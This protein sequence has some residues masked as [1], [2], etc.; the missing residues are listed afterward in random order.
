MWAMASLT[1][2]T[3]SH[4]HG[5]GMRKKTEWTKGRKSYGKTELA[6]FVKFK[7]CCYHVTFHLD[8]ELEHTL[9]AG[10]SGDHCVQVWRWSDIC[11]REEAICAKS[12]QT[13][14]RTPL[15]C[16]SSLEWANNNSY[17]Q[18][19]CALRQHYCLTCLCLFCG[20]ESFRS[21][22]TWNEKRRQNCVKLW[23]AWRDAIHKKMP[24]PRAPGAKH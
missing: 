18:N 4:R 6:I 24:T 19:G 11:L 12:L 22:R 17:C 20:H 21:R 1:V 23:H 5:I 14:R 16:I 7:M 9:D 3:H 2:Q 10:S 15:H 13:D 8:L